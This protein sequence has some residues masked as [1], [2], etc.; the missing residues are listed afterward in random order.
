M[1]LGSSKVYYVRTYKDMLSGRLGLGG[2]KC[3]SFIVSKN[4][5]TWAVGLVLI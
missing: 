3:A 4:S 2:I 1:Y 5:K